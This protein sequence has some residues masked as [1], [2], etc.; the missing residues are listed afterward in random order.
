VATI[1]TQA[2][3]GDVGEFLA[4]VGDD[5]RRE[6][7]LQVCA[8]LEHVTGSAP[9]MWGPAIVGFG[10]TTY[11]NTSGTHDWF[12]VGF[13]P[14]QKATTLYGL[15]DARLERDDLFAQLGRHTTG[16]GCVYLPSLAD[17]D[18]GVLEDIVRHAWAA[19]DA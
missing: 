17:V 15:L 10:A 4:A 6:D 11:T 3:D 12:V 14:R 18:L 8:L 1:S 7:A 19:S 13:S 2:N 16:K 5:R 9:T